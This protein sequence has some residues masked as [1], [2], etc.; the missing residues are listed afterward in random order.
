MV[1]SLLFERE[2]VLPHD[3]EPGSPSGCQL[4]VYGL[5]EGKEYG[6]SVFFRSDAWPSWGCSD[7]EDFIIRFEQ[8]WLFYGWGN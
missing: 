7:V 6:Y 5:V 1:T 2:R 3:S 4:N 8:S